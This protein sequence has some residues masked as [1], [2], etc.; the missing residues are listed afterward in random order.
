MDK[1]LNSRLFNIGVIALIFASLMI[2]IGMI[3]NKDLNC[4]SQDSSECR[5]GNGIFCQSSKFNGSETI[6]ESI[7]KIRNGSDE[8]TNHVY[9][10]RFL[11]G[12]L[13]TT[14][15]IFIFALRKWPTIA[16]FFTVFL[17]I[18]VCGH[19]TQGFYNY[20]YY[21]HLNDN[22]NSHL[23]NIESKLK[24]IECAGE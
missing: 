1:F 12:A 11:L 7:D 5:D 14:L 16:E 8:T 4:P 22:I 23:K 19:F 18:F 20:H 17:L 9:W 21:K 10:R 24:E 13:P 15:A 2:L 3:E 6:D